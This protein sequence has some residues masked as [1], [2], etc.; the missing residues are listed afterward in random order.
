MSHVS[1]LTGGQSA[2]I[3]YVRERARQLAPD[4]AAD[5]I[6]AVI[7]DHG[8]I[9]LN[10]HPDRLLAD[11]RTVASALAAE[12]RYR[13]QF[14]TRISN[15]SR[16][17]FPGGDRDRWERELFGGAYHQGVVLP[18]DRPKYG[19]L[20]LLGHLDG[21]APRFGSCHVRLRPEAN[22]RA[23]FTFGDSHL[24]PSDVGTVDAFRPVLAA[25][26]ASAADG[27]ALGVPVGD[28]SGRLRALAEP[29][30]DAVMSRALD[31]YIEAQVH[32]PIVLAED[33]EAVVVDPSFRGTEVGAM[34][35]AT[36]VP[37]EWHLGYVLTADDVPDDFR[38]P[39]T[40]KFARY[41]A[42]RCDTGGRIDAEIIGRAAASIVR[43]PA[44]W[45]RWGDQDELLQLVK[46][47]W[48]TLVAFGRPMV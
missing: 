11:G 38:T 32:G 21:A 26:M 18:A 27:S 48:H 31:D 28:L 22:A 25:L 14:E 37:V 9:T 19:A 1:G 35:A 46:Y 39:E 30:P 36:G 45:D 23:T 7:R 13:G 47:V 41:V 29:R 5:A 10:F 8:R 2:A 24:E 43:S 42:D 12:G 4:P 15:G 6:C 34:L 33:A 17:A 20:N 44:T 40:P 3:A 16:T